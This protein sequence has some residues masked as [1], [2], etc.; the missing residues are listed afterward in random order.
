MSAQRLGGI[1]LCVLMG[2]PAWAD[3][4]GPVP[5]EYGYLVEEIPYSFEDISGTGTRVL[6]GFDD[7]S[8]GSIGLGFN[9]TFFG[10]TYTD[11]SWS[12]NGLGTFHLGGGVNGQFTNQD[13]ITRTP[14]APFGVVVGDLV[15]SAACLWDD[16]QLFQAGTDAAYY[17]TLGTSPNRYFIVQW[18]DLGGFSTSPSLVTFQIKV[19]ESSNIIEC[20]YKDVDSGD[21]RTDGRSSTVGI[22]LRVHDSFDNQ[23]T[24]CDETVVGLPYDRSGYCAK[25][26]D[27]GGGGPES[28]LQWACGG[29]G[30]E[31]PAP[32]SESSVTDEFALRFTPNASAGD[33]ASWGWVWRY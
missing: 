10:T 33:E 7:A 15:G 3:S 29:T 9:F 21:F 30:P 6:A 23:T 12:I 2:S 13:L 20:H 8:T 11:A 32:S 14:S 1:L 4:V 17:E 31:C 28:G 19:F 27:A 16:W 25:N 22:S 5:D 24:E 26:T 18:N